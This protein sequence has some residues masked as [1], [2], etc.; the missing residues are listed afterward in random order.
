MKIISTHLF[1]NEIELL[2]IRLEELYDYVDY[3]VLVQ[4]EITVQDGSTQP[5]FGSFEKNIHLFEKYK[6]IFKIY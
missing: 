4:S 2:L 3:F 5:Y 6:C 1:M